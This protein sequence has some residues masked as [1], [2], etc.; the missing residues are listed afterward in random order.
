LGKPAPCE[1]NRSFAPG[2]LP[3]SDNPGPP[4]AGLEAPIGPVQ[5]EQVWS[6]GQLEGGGVQP[7]REPAV[8]WKLMPVSVAAGAQLRKSWQ[9]AAR[10]E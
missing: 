5:R 3:E 2:P 8:I 1:A 4:P 10:S 7:G 6:S 9:V